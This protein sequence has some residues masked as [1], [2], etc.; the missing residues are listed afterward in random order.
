V[1]GGGKSE[2][3]KSLQPM[4]KAS[5]SYVKDYERDFAKVAEILDMDFSKIY[6][7]GNTD[8]RETRPIMSPERS[9]GSVVKL[10]TPSDDYHRRVQRLVAG[11]AA[12]DPRARVHRETLPSGSGR[13][14]QSALHGRHRQRLPG[15]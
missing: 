2:I 7:N 9:L 15:P 11:A 4:I 13:R 10:L 1:S 8:G 5:P 14:H 6:K 3:S 12:N